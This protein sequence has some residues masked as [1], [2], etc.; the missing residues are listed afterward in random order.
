MNTNFSDAMQKLYDEPQAIMGYARKQGYVVNTRVYQME[1]PEMDYAALVP[2]NTNLPE[3]ALGQYTG[4]IENVGQAEWQSGYA[5][6][7]PLADVKQ[8]E[9]MS[10]FDMYAIGY[11]WNLE[12]LGKAM[13]M[14][15]PL[16]D[17]RA[18][19]A[20]QGAEQFLW[21]NVIT[22][23]KG[24][25]WTGLI[26]SAYVKPIAAPDTGTATPNT[27]WVLINGTG[28]K[29]AEQI[30]A[31]LNGLILG[32][33]NIDD[34]GIMSSLLADTILLPPRAFKYI[35]ETPYGVTA[36]N[37]TILTFFMQNN[38]YTRRTGQ[39]I[40]VL[41]MPALSRAATEGIAGGGRAVGY[42]NSDDVLSLPLPMAYRFLPAYQDGALN[43][44]VPGIARVGEL[45][46]IKPNAIRYLDGV[47]PV[48]A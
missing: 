30:V 8:S 24:K 18:M 29:T 23:S 48:P 15:V 5:K 10:Q 25:K 26:N 39:Q 7:I 36:P 20:R 1:Y 31:E 40:K 34:I 9:I 2:V 22:G 38:E 17:R 21:R 47:T 44:V 4:Q 37:M 33:Q 46:V 28:N 43:F 42:R 16:S 6:D 12:E 35:S 32:N 41:D 27:A 11:Q 45:D 14:G 3:F 13:F 19:A